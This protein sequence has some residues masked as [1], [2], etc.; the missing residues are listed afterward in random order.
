MGRDIHTRVCALGRRAAGFGVTH[1]HACSD[2]VHSRSDTDRLNYASRFVRV[3]CSSYI[4]S[5]KLGTVTMN[6][7][8][9]SFQR[10]ITAKKKRKPLGKNKPFKLKQTS[11]KKH[12]KKNKPAEK[13]KLGR[14]KNM[15]QKPL[16]KKTTKEHP[17]TKKPFNE[18]KVQNKHFLHRLE[19]RTTRKK[20]LKKKTTTFKE[21]KNHC[22]RTKKLLKKKKKTLERNK[23]QKK[24]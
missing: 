15:Q 18:N 11:S 2:C 16:K 6:D 23:F 9:H 21:K 17:K 19:K 10:K 13:K 12:M 7:S 24:K 14:K 22:Q 5:I 3:I 20:T 8:K 1:V 4:V